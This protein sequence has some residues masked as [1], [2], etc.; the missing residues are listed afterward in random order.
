MGE[1]KRMT[2]EMKTTAAQMCRRR[3]EIDR[4]K[5]SSDEA[6]EG[7]C[8]EGASREESSDKSSG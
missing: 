6:G 4:T 3:S 5:V 8:V 7:Y 1:E 2:A